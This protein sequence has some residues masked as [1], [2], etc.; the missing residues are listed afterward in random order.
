MLIFFLVS[1]GRILKYMCMI[2]NVIDYI[3][4][5]II[6]VY[7]C[8]LFFNKVECVYFIICYMVIINEL[9]Y[10]LYVYV[11]ID[12]FVQCIIKV[13]N[14]VKSIFFLNVIYVMIL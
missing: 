2:F 3:D 6:Q 4:L 13:F 10:K 7:K 12:M 5:I 8:V 11:Y 14:N 1:W 9:I